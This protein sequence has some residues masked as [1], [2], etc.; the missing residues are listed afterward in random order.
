MADDGGAGVTEVGEQARARP[1]DPETTDPHLLSPLGGLNG[2]SPE[3]PDWFR[4]AIDTPHERDFVEVDGARIEWL[5]WGERGKPGLLLLHGNGANAD[6]W[7]FVAP[8]L[9]GS[10]RVAALSWSGM[11]GSDHR[12]SYTGTLFMEEALAV[13]E[14]AGLGAQFAVAGH[15][16]GGIPTVVLAAMRPER[17]TQAI[18]I[19]TPLGE[20]R[21]PSSSRLQ[22]GHRAYPELSEALSRFRWAPVQ[23]SPNLYITDFIARSSLKQVDSGWTWKFDPLLWANFTPGGDVDGLASQITVPLTYMWGEQSVLAEHGVVQKIRKLLP[24]GTRFVGLPDAHHH[25]MADQPLALVAA[26]RALLA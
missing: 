26:L 7:R 14:A 6:W 10:H 21:R 17:L 13:A 12:A 3:A 15:S 23:P 19:D 25:V 18:I 20:N 24:E 1:F 5:A 2:V 22:R 9:T 8:F 11:G 16:F 4:L